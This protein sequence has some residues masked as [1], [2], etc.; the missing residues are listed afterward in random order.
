MLIYFLLKMFWEALD[1]IKTP[2][3]YVEQITRYFIQQTAHQNIFPVTTEENNSQY[4]WNSFAEVSIL[5]CGVTVI[6]R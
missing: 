4:Y 1:S 3:T 2:S 6:N 5:S